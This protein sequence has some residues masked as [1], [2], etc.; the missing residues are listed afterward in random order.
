MIR[1][2]SP[3]RSASDAARPVHG[4][5]QS[6]QPLDSLHGLSTALHGLFSHFSVR[7][8][9][10]L[11]AG[12]ESTCD[13]EGCVGGTGCRRRAAIPRSGAAEGCGGAALPRARGPRLSARMLGAA[14]PD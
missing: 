14:S 11:R 10:S 7:S 6:V 1:L 5:A 12:C 3:T 4:A 13:S 9:W 8:V 2:I